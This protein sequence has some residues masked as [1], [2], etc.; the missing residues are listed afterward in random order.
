MRPLNSLPRP[1][2]SLGYGQGQISQAAAQAAGDGDADLHLAADLDH[3]VGV[4]A[5]V[6]PHCEVPFIPGVAHPSDC[7]P[8]DVA[9]ALGGVGSALV[10]PGHDRL[11]GSGPGRPGSGQQ[12]PA[13]PVQL[14]YVAPA[15]AAQEGPQSRPSRKRGWTGS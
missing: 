15:E 14:A 1:P 5:A 4:E 2:V 10:Q 3:A 11:A 7:L 6:G 8:Q 9:S 12:F 13:D